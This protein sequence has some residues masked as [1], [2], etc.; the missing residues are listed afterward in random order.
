MILKVKK[1]DRDAV[2]PSYTHSFDAGL[3]FHGIESVTVNPGE[4]GKIRSGVAIEIPDG[5]VGLCW[6]RSGIAT[7]NKIKIVGGVI[8]S[9][10]RGELKLC[11][12]NLG[13]EPFTFEKGDSVC[14]ILIQKVEHVEVVE[15]DDLSSSERGDKGF[16]SGK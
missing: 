6:D 12:I 14:Q 8:D 10:F 16:G 11:V 3:D 15:S 7:K 4:I 9:G 2:L 5:Y 1:L 13:R